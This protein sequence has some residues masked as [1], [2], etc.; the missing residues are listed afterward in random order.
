MFLELF[1]TCLCLLWCL[2]VMS[3]LLWCE[4]PKHKREYTDSSKRAWRPSDGQDTFA[5]SHPR[6]LS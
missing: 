1:W 4:G 5:R 2:L 3:F 6:Y